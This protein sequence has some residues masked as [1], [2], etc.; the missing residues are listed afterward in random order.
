MLFSVKKQPASYVGTLRCGMTKS[1]MS[2]EQMLHEKLLFL[3]KDFPTKHFYRAVLVVSQCV[4]SCTCTLAFYGV[5]QVAV[6]I[7]C[8]FSSIKMCLNKCDIM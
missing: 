3:Q 8:T 2:V 1:Q 5:W 7:L 4:V 6:V